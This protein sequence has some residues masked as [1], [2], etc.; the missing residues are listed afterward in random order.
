METEG[1]RGEEGTFLQ[2]GPVSIVV[3]IV[4]RMVE[5]M[6]VEIMMVRMKRTVTMEE[7]DNEDGGN[8]EEANMGD[9]CVD[10]KIRDF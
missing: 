4:V 1:Q 6:I 7:E 9:N 3:R 10:Q 2:E 8:K 5:I